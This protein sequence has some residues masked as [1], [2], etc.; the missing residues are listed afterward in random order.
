MLSEIQEYRERMINAIT[1]SFNKDTCY[2]PLQ[3]KWTPERPETGHCVIVSAYILSVF[4]G[5]IVYNEEYHHYWNILEDSGELDLTIKQFNLPVD[6]Q[7]LSIDGYYSDTIYLL[8]N[9]DTK[10]R[11]D[12]FTSRVQKYLI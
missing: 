2:P 11:Y 10:N 8:D 1:R 3:S 5:I 12:L 7:R 4:G 9:I 6:H